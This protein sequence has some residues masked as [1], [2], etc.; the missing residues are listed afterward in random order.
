MRYWFLIVLLVL[1]TG[2]VFAQSAPPDA[3]SA[4]DP[5]VQVNP[6]A[7]AEFFKNYGPWAMVL[8]LLVAIVMLYRSMERQ[9]RDFDAVVSKRQE[10]FVALIERL[11]NSFLSK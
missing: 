2:A 10:Q 5:F 11:M 6:K 4:V 9:R 1:F 7:A 8:V 3:K